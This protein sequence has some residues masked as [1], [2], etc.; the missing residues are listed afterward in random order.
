VIQQTNPLKPKKKRRVKGKQVERPETER[1]RKDRL[2]PGYD[3]LKKLSIGIPENEE[4]D[5]D[6]LIDDEI[7]DEP[8]GDEDDCLI[9]MK[10]AMLATNNPV[11]QQAMKKTISEARERKKKVNCEPGNPW[12]DELGRMTSHDKAASWSIGNQ[13]GVGKPDCNYGKKKKTGSGRSTSW[14]KRECGREDVTDPNDKAKHRCKDGSV[15]KENDEEL[16]DI[17]SAW[18]ETT[19]SFDAETRD[20]LDRILDRD[21]QFLKNVIYLIKPHV[22][23]EREAEREDNQ[24]DKSQSNPN[25]KMNEKKKNRHKGLDR[26]QIRNLCAR[27]GF[28]GWTDFLMKLSAIEQAKKGT[29]NRQGKDQ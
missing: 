10:W 8:E 27:S 11:T 12:R 22:D 3:D 23:R 1:E 4:P 21:P 25:S 16:I 9:P 20:R 7:N 14:T 13:D 15:V 17:S 6:C 5:N 28:F 2:M 24:R 19:N 29:I 26:E 18:I